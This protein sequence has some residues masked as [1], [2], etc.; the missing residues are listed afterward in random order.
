M[1]IMFPRQISSNISTMDTI[2]PGKAS[3]CQQ[4][5]KLKKIKIQIEY[6]NWFLIHFEAIFPS[7]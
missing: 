2:D 3:F 6:K 7:T 5:S 4:C 1:H